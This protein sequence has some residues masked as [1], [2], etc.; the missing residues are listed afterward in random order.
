MLDPFEIRLAELLADALAGVDNLGPVGRFGS[1]PAPGPGQVGIA[2]R[3]IQ[4]TPHPHVGDDRRAELRQAGR[5]RLRPTLHLEGITTILLA[6]AA[7][8]PPADDDS[9]AR[10]VAMLDRVLLA[11]HSEA[12]HSGRAFA[13]AAD[14]G[15]EL[16]SFRFSDAS[17]P[18]DMAADPRSLQLSYGFEGRFWPVQEA[19]EGDLITDL[20]TRLAVMPLRLPERITAQ[21]GGAGLSVPLRLDLA[22]TGGAVSAIAARLEGTAPPGALVGD[23]TAAPAGYTGFAVDAVGVADLVYQ[24]PAD[25]AGRAEVRVETRLTH[26]D[27]P[28]IPLTR[29]EIE[30]LPS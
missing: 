29:F 25:L 20:P 30:V 27:R 7:P 10:L 1:V 19:P 8:R 21:A 5:I 16:D 28:S 6:A 9:R 26:P 14:Q 2:V 22:V 23:G 11:L 3:I 4:F 13:T 24:P 15:F 12:V 17:Q 18:V